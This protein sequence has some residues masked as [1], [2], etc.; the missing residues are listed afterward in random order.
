L[1]Q[2]GED[3]AGGASSDTSQ[4]KPRVAIELVSAGVLRKASSG[5]AQRLHAGMWRML[6]QMPVDECRDPIPGLREFAAHE[7]QLLRVAEHEAV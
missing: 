3:V 1:A 6:K 7:Q 5:R 2:P 4:S